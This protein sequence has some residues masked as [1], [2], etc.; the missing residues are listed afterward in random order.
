MLRVILP[1]PKGNQQSGKFAV[2]ENLLRRFKKDIKEFQKKEL[3]ELIGLAPKQPKQSRDEADSLLA[4]YVQR[5]GKNLR[6]RAVY[7]GKT[8]RAFAQKDGTVRYKN[9]KYMSPSAAGKAVIL[10]GCNGW[11]FWRY[12]RAPGQWVRLSKLRSS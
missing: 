9:R 10:R 3:G 1:K 7:K 11:A 12:Q 8:Y 6:L 4:E 5:T 2:S